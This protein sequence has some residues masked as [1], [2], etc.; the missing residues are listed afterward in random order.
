M[1]TSNQIVKALFLSL[2]FGLL[3]T[4]AQ[5]EHK[6]LKA[7]P[8]E[9]DGMKRFVIILPEKTRSEEGNYKVEIAV[10]KVMETDGVN[11]V[12]LGGK[13]ETKPLKGWGFT[14]YEVGKLGPGFSTKIG[15]PPGTP[16]VKKFVNGPS[17]IIGYNSR[18]PIVVYVP[19]DAEVQ[20]RIW[21]AQPKFNPAKK[22]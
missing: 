7:F 4:T 18:L 5:A 2:V 22:G 15:V 16:K 17:T 14:Y 11:K 12:S 6:Y 20:Y 9:K 13:I 19:D 8:K 10:G 3:S 1:N 21:K